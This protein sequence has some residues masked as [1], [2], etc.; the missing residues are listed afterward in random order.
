MTI[1]D[2]VRI[3]RRSWLLLL[4]C[5]ILGVTVAA[6]YVFTRPIYYVA[7]A[8]G[9]VVAGD[10]ASVGNVMAG[11]SVAEQRASSYLTLINTSAV[12][13]RTDS[14]LVD[15]GN[16]QAAS[17]SLSAS[18]VS[19]TSLIK[20]TGTG[21]TAQNAQDLANAGLQALSV[22]ALRL[23]T[24]AQTQG[25]ETG[26]EEMKQLTSVYI[27]AYEPAA[28]PGGAVRPN[29]Y[30]MLAMGLAGGLAL[31]VVI[32]VIRRQFDVRVRNQSDV[33]QLTAR[34]VLGVIPETRDLKKQREGGVMINMGH[35]GEAL[36][37]LRTNLRFV[38]V[39]EPPRAVVIT[40]ANPGEGK[41]TIASNLAMLIAKSG[42]DV[43]L[44]DA[45]LRKPMQAKVF[46]ADGHIGLTQVLSGDVS[47]AD[48]LVDTSTDRLLLLP[49]G[50]IPP[51]PSELAGSK[52]MQEL[53]HELSR[54]A[55]V[56]LD[57]PPML[58][59]T[60]AGLLAAA[61]DGA[62]LVGVVGHT[63][64]NELGLCAKQLD[65]LG[66]VLLGSVLNR[67]PRRTMGDVL[68]GYGG[69]ATKAY[70]TGYYTGADGKRKKFAATNSSATEIP[71][72]VG[73]INPRGARR[74]L[75]P[76]VPPPVSDTAP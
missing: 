68:Y 74:S 8:T 31:G 33:E 59:V 5:A 70:Y 15:R 19:N 21:A 25:R 24:Y 27:L 56:V 38:Q 6:G 29:M 72:E 71:V 57:A 58:S 50:R 1:V 48:A 64:K 11:N 30:R 53:V 55:F 60:D 3:L 32:A 2:L 63:L 39:D 13:K 40:S 37:Q 17:G 4:A 16:P 18:L 62:I 47:V 22:E 7:S 46:G 69:Y 9:V 52:R 43:V 36:R 54:Q 14:Y 12:S 41:S 51:N 75:E 67:A 66:A 61:A 65:Q 34:S 45:D 35:A 49:A 42:Q 76:A 73:D 28:L 10:S 23:E 20:V 26:I 44:I